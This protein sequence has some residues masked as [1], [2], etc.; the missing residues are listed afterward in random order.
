MFSSTFAFSAES[1]LIPTITFAKGFL[2]S[3]NFTQSDDY[4]INDDILITSD[5]G[6]TLTANV[7]TP[8]SGAD[9]YP[10]IIFI[11][12][13][14]MNEYEY[15]S[16]AQKLAADGYVVL[17]YST[18]GFGSSEGL[19]DTA[20]PNDTMDLS[21]VIDWLIENTPTDPERIGVAGISYGAGIA[22]IG[23]AHDSRIKAVASMSGW[24]S[25]IESL[26]GNSTTPLAW[27]QILDYSSQITGRPDPVIHEYYNV[28]LNQEVERI[29]ELTEWGRPRSPISFIDQINSNGTAIYLNKNWGDYLF[30]SNN[31]LDFYQQ[32]NTPKH[33]TLV[34]GTHA[35]NELL[36]MLGLGSNKILKNARRWFDHF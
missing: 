8:T 6:V 19:I 23:A 33:L 21:I 20:G 2:D 17:S 14:T 7:I 18:R 29:D 30:P 32:L 16:E 31:T 11:N 4:T 36:G 34:P 35:S 5:D 27:G 25:L 28:L 10:A 24:G 9:S 13:W 1:P 12:S 3:P 26:Y 22:L 15:T